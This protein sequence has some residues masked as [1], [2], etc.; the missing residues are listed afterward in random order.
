GLNYSTWVT[1]DREVL[2]Y[3]IVSGDYVGWGE[4]TLNYRCLGVAKRLA[5]KLVGRDASKK[6]SILDPAFLATTLAYQYYAGFNRRF[7]QVREGFSQALWDLHGK[8]KNKPF[9][10]MI[11]ISDFSACDFQRGMPVIH[12]YSPSEMGRI[13]EIWIEKGFRTFKIKLRGEAVQDIEAMRVI[14][15]LGSDVKILIAD[16]N[17][18][19]KKTTELK[20]AAE[21]F[22]ECGLEYLQN[23]IRKPF[24]KY[25]GLSKSLGIKFTSDNTAYW[26]NTRR[27]IGLQEAELINLHPNIMGGVDNTLKL[28]SYA[29]KS[30][31]PTITGGSGFFG[32]QD[33]CFQKM[34]FCINSSFPTE[35]IGLQNYFCSDLDQ[36]Y[37]YEFERLSILTNDLE[38]SDGKI[39]DRR[40]S[41]F[42]IDV[43]IS[44]LERVTKTKFVYT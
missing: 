3:K 42:G 2:I 12:V 13:A 5:R 31:I 21:G 35:N 26:P 36:Y 19:Y 20:R 1:T 22:R 17:Y 32:I 41:G 6:E 18:G 29:R 28:V 7:R 34:S 30:G 24:W 40:E 23:P 38:V 11:S 16:A 33:K 25:R 44:A 8:V 43:N 37:K 39:F 9:A 10:E 14:K 15:S 27:V 4:S